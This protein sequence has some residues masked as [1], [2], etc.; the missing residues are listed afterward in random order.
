MAHQRITSLTKARFHKIQLLQNET[1]GTGAY[2]SVYKAKCDDLLCAAKVIH[3]ALLQPIQAQPNREHRLVQNRFQLECDLL[4]DI[5]HPNI[6]QYLGQYTDPTTEGIV[7]LMELMDDSLRSF[8][9]NESNK[10]SY[11]VQISIATD[12]ATALSFLH[13]NKILHRD[14]SSNNILLHR[15]HRAK[16]SDFGMAKVAVER[17]QQAVSN[18]TCPGTEVY[19]PP[20]ALDVRPR[21]SEKGD[22]FSLGVNIIQILTRKF[23]A[24]SERMEH[25]PTNDPRFPMGVA[26]CDVPERRRREN[27]ISEISPEDPLLK[28]ALDCLKDKENERPSAHTLCQQLTQLK[29]T[30]EQTSDKQAHEREIME[31]KE[32]IDILKYENTDLRKDLRELR[33]TM[34]TSTEQREEEIQQSLQTITARQQEIQSL[35]EELSKAQSTIREKDEIISVK[36]NAQKVLEDGILDLHT[37][38]QELHK[39]LKYYKNMQPQINSDVIKLKWTQGA[40][41]PCTMIRETDLIVGGSM[42][43]FKPGQSQQIFCFNSTND[44]WYKLPDSPVLHTTLAFV[45][46]LP[47]LVGGYYMDILLQLDQKNKKWIQQ[48][49][50]MPTKRSNTIT[51]CTRSQLI[52]AGGQLDGRR[53]KLT[54]IEVMDSDTLQWSKTGDL[55]EAVST[56]TAVLCGDRVYISNGGTTVHTCSV[57]NMTKPTQT[58]PTQIWSKT[59]NMPVRESTLVSYKN[60]LLGVGG[61]D[62]DRKPTAAVYMYNH[63]DNQWTLLGSMNRPRQSCF[64]AALPDDRLMVVGGVTSQWGRA[65]DDVEFASV[66]Y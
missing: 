50:P 52:V 46:G 51:L 11:Y 22:M 44:T 57:Y 34:A 62:S 36:M 24:P 39:T 40:K 47:V 13:S 6:V 12:V 2:G 7:L 43:Y 10:I 30:H 16:L 53:E 31:L 38:N 1:L 60:R 3:T 55:P 21:Y 64:A 49:S 33:R 45:N 8:L 29:A 54:T 61:C 63:S 27:H 4:K 35:R 26:K 58:H 65:S 25:V 56:S 59:A 37:L 20:E 9:E 18:T 42:V 15:E 41:A 14:L 28:I 32:T 23:P 5:T 17:R 19:M 48:F 66:D